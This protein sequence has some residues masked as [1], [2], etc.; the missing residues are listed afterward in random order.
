MGGPVVIT[1]GGTITVVVGSV[2]R[3]ILMKNGPGTETGGSCYRLSIK[4]A[5]V[6][7]YLICAGDK[8]KGVC[9]GLYWTEQYRY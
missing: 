4:C 5:M 9:L 6:L 8:P 3:A 2:G 7:L 1:L